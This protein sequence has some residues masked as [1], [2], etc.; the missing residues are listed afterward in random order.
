MTG[1]AGTGFFTGMLDLDTFLQCRITNGRPR[2]G[3]DNGAFRT[4]FLV[5]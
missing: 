1:S 2:F 4:D 3:L 5:G